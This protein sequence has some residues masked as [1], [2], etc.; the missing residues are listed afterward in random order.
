ISV[1]PDPVTLLEATAHGGRLLALGAVKKSRT[2]NEDKCKFM[3]A[4][5]MRY[6]LL[7]TLTGFNLLFRY[8]G[9]PRRFSSRRGCRTVSAYPYTFRYSRFDQLVADRIPYQCCA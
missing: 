5:P 8:P 2:S 7:C 3:T 4:F 6:F 9:G 1:S